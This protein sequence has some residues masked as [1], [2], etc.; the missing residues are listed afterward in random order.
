MQ[1]HVSNRCPWSFENFGNIGFN[2]YKLDTLGNVLSSHAQNSG[3]SGLTFTQNTLWRSDNVHDVVFEIDT[4]ICNYLICNHKVT[5]FS[6]L[7][8][9]FS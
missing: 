1:K 2:I 3:A 5:T 4:S 7:I 6:I 9:E 8:P